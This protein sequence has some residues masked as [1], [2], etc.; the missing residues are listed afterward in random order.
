MLWNYIFD[1][2]IDI[3]VLTETWLQSEDQ[4]WIQTCDLNINQFRIQ[5][6]NRN[7]GRGGGLAIVYRKNYKV[8]K[9]PNMKKCNSFEHAIWKITGKNISLVI[10]AIYHPPYTKKN[11]A[12]NSTFLNE[13][14]D[15][16][17]E[18]IPK[19]QNFIITGDMNLHVN[20]SNDPDGIIMKENITALGFDQYVNFPTHRSGHTLDLVIT[21]HHNNKFQ[22][23]S[24]YPGMFLSDHCAVEYII[25]TK[26]ENIIS[27]T[28]TFRNMKNLDIEMLTDSFR[29][30]DLTVSDQ[31]D[32]IVELF[33]KEVGNIIDENVP[34]IT[35]T[36]IHRKPKPWFNETIKS[37]KRELRRKE[38]VWRRYQQP[39]QWIALKK[40]RNKYVFK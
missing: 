18:F 8:K 9:E 21:E 40:V 10:L 27:E 12:S 36:V 20:D 31:V 39:H 1:E 16:L 30:I 15:F 2:N 24:C 13:F 22:I 34:E 6:V 32:T 38:H 3:S 5:T 11:A 35:R 19:Y 29:N 25:N 23:T 14:L 26:K 7:N 4:L 28:K 17:V 37:L 33:E